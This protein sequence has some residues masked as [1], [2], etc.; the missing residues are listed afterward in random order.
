[1][2]NLFSLE[3]SILSALE[4]LKNKFILDYYAKYYALQVLASEY[5]CASYCLYMYVYGMFNA[6]L[7]LH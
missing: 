1:M 2:S 5:R 3:A 7:M 6:N 4:I